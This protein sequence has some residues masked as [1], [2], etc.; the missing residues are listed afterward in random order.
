[1]VLAPLKTPSSPSRS[2]TVSAEER[3]LRRREEEAAL[4]AATQA[5]AHG[6]PVLLDVERP[7]PGLRELM[8]LVDAAKNAAGVTL[9]AKTRLGRM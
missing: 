4:H 5:R 6:I 7:R 3:A 8:P 9:A 2:G 1:M